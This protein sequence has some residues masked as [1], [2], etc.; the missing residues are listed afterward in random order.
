MNKT[1][2]KTVPALIAIAAL[3][4]C[5]RDA[6][7]DD[8]NDSAFVFGDDIQQS[9][10]LKFGADN[11][12]EEIGND[13]GPVAVVNGTWTLGDGVLFLD[14]PDTDE[15]FEAKIA[16]GKLELTSSTNSDDV[17]LGAKA[18]KVTSDDITNNYS[19][20]ACE[21]C[22]VSLD[23]DGTGEIGS[24]SLSGFSWSVTD[25]GTVAMD[26][27][28]LSEAEYFFMEQDLEE[29]TYDYVSYQGR[30]DQTPALTSG[31]LKVV[32]EEG[33][34]GTW[35]KACGVVDPD[36]FLVLYDTVTLTI[37]GETIE[38]DF[39]L[40][41]DEECTV[42]FANEPNPRSSGTIVVGEEFELSGGVTVTPF[43][44]HI[45]T[46]NDGPVD[47]YDYSIFRLNGNQLIFGEKTQ[48]FDGTTPEKRHNQLSSHRTFIRQ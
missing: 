13:D 7:Y 18:L 31:Q 25:F 47:V 39:R 28:P 24:N 6:T 4:G 42:P 10:I 8:L 37:E 44:Q 45:T 32:L 14:R 38:S 16:A 35:A 15:S 27:A 20:D 30:A 5:K 48:E 33:I 11:T 12:F 26:F 19:D 29:G 36:A 46:Y 40:Y 43:D 3:G 1:F 41:T 34:D 21:T 2:K 22:I 17:I 23:D 9:V